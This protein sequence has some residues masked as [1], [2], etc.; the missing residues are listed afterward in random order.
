MAYGRAVH[1]ACHVAAELI[2]RGEQLPGISGDR[3]L[4]FRV[5]I[6]GRKTEGF[7]HIS[8]ITGS[9]VR[10]VSDHVTEGQRVAATYL[11]FAY[12]AD[13]FSMIGVKQPQE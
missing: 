7:V 3:P 13:Q 11:G 10:E 9:N 4:G 8:Q 1:S 12:D 5:K 2:E 6:D